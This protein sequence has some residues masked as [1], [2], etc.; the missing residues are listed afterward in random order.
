MANQVAQLVRVPNPGQQLLNG[1]ATQIHVVDLSS[2]KDRGPLIVD[3]LAKLALCFQKLGLIE[4]S[5][6]S[7]RRSHDDGFVGIARL[8]TIV[9]P[10][11]RVGHFNKPLYILFPSE[12]GMQRKK[13]F[14]LRW[15]ICQPLI[16]AHDVSAVET[17]LYVV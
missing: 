4:G 6:G 10:Y 17:S 16:L 12:G 15:C 7:F 9:P 13:R 3:K 1:V 5:S 8:K 2:L 14:K 11:Y